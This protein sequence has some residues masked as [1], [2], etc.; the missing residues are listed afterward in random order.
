MSSPQ[1]S[2]EQNEATDEAPLEEVQSPAPEEPETEID[3]VECPNCRHEFTG[4][5]CPECGQEADPSATVVEVIGGFFREL[6]DLEHGFWPTFVGLTLRPGAVLR[7]YLSGVRAGL[8]SPGRYLLAAV[9]VSVGV[10]QFLAWI[11]ASPP[12]GADSEASP[13][14]NGPEAEEGIGK[15]LEVVGEQISALSGGSYGPIALALLITGLLAVLLYHLFG[16]E[17]KRM[18]EALG[19]SS[20]LAAHATFLDVGA[21]LLYVPVASLYAGHPI[22]GSPLLW[23]TIVAGYVGFASHQGF[24][25]DWESALKGAFAV[26]WTVVETF[27]VVFVL[28]VVYA[29]GLMVVYP[30]YVPSETPTWVVVATYVTGSLLCALPL[31]LHAG[32]ELYYRWR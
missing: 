8:I 21:D 14:P 28:A 6:V 7:D 9:I 26:V 25:P 20:F 29:A 16:D 18:G 23:A 24:G 13:S 27:S 11:G 3:T 15:A 10:D 22:E 17:M 1:A 12:P 31:F 2:S 32:V 4:N 19:V 30:G 5:Y